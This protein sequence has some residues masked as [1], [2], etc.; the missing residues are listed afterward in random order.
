MFFD[1]SQAMTF[2]QQKI[3]RV[4]FALL[5]GCQ[6]PNSAKSPLRLTLARRED[7]LKD[8]ETCL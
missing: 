2:A 6:M 4:E 3:A 7:G 5:S 8:Y 1:L